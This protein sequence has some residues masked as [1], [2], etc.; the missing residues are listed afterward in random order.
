[1]GGSFGRRIKKNKGVRSLMIN[2]WYR[3][4]K[5][6]FYGFCKHLIIVN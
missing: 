1:M 4:F 3:Y 5:Y 6:F 2:D